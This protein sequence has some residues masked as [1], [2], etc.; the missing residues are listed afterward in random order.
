[1]IN[2]NSWLLIIWLFSCNT[3]ERNYKKNDIQYIDYLYSVID[4]YDAAIEYKLY[5]KNEVYS[6]GDSLNLLF[7]KLNTTQIIHDTNY[8]KPILFLL[9]K[10]YLYIVKNVKDVDLFYVNNASKWGGNGSYMQY[11]INVFCKLEPNKDKKNTY[12]EYVNQITDI[13]CVNLIIS[14]ASGYTLKNASHLTVHDSCI[15]FC[16]KVCD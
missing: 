15:N 1:M 16:P 14:E 2:C 8:R 9:E 13:A 12:N 3:K 10:K 4:R 6:L 5:K 11:A 7:S